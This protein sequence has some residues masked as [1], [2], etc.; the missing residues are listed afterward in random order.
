M[1]SAHLSGPKCLFV[2][3]VLGWATAVYLPSLSIALLGLSPLS[4]N[5]NLFVDTFQ[6]ADEVSPAAKLAYGSLFGGFLLAAR[7]VPVRRQIFV[8]AG[9]GVV[10]MLVVVA[11]LPEGWS[12]G[13]GIGLNG[14]RF[15]SIQTVIYVVGGLVSGVVFS[16]S[17]SRCRLRNQNPSGH[18]SIKD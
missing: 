6:I 7:A 9:I 15:G 17:E 11:F 14:S 18:Q 16:T 8:D 1:K 5:G 12:R 2:A 10:C 4:P 3:W 13:F